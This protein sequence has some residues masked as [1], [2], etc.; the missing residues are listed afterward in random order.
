MS[1]PAAELIADLTR[2]RKPPVRNRPLTAEWLSAQLELAKA[3]A[4]L[5]EFRARAWAGAFREE[6]VCSPGAVKRAVPLLQNETQNMNT[7]EYLISTGCPA[8]APQPSVNG[9]SRSVVVGRPPSN[10]FALT[11]R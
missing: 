5:R 10:T 9:M 7:T 4:E 1:T 11:M 2:T 3:Q 6:R 8:T